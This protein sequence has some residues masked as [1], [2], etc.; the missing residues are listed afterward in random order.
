V[1]TSEEEIR[2]F[3]VVCRA[4]IK[5]GWTAFGRARKDHPRVNLTKIGF[6]EFG[7][8]PVQVCSAIGL[9]R[10]DIAE[11]TRL[12]RIRKGGRHNFPTRSDEIIAAA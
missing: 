11:I 9:A 3:S 6:D 5:D 10:D 2:Q 7:L 4:M 12:D 8:T 1:K